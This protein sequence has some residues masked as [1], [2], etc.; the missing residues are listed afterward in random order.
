MG[1]HKSVLAPLRRAMTDL[2]RL[3]EKWGSAG[4]LET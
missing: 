4:E 3:L 1:K 2:I